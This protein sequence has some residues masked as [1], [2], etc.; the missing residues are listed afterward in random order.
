MKAVLLSLLFAMMLTNYAHAQQQVD[1]LQ[2]G[3]LIEKDG[4]KR[5]TALL[6]SLGGSI[7]VASSALMDADQRTPLIALGGVMMGIAIPL[8]I[9]AAGS[10]KKA[11]RMLQGR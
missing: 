7:L 4:K 9:S 2:V 5:S 3:Q 1:L 6:L 10:A 8:N 11:G